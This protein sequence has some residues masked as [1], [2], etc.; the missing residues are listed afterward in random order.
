M[1]LLLMLGESR[2][3]G[4]GRLQGN[5]ST[6]GALLLSETPETCSP[7]TKM[8]RW[9]MEVRKKKETRRTGDHEAGNKN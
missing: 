3:S 1:P 2:R 9:K 8:S 6:S 4:S 7:R 5:G